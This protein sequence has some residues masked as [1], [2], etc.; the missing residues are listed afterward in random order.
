MH[1]ALRPNP[2]NGY[3]RDPGVLRRLERRFDDDHPW[4][5]GQLEAYARAP[6]TF[7]I[8]RVLWLKGVE[9]A[10]EETT[11]L[12]F[13]SVAH[14]ILERFYAEFMD[15]LPLSLTGSAEIRL[16]EISEEVC[17]ERVEKG[18]W[19]GVAA[20]WEQ[21]RQ[22]IVTGVRDYV[23]WELEYMAGQ[24][25][26]PVHTELRFGWDDERTFVEGED[27]WGRMSRVSLRGSIDRV[28]RVGVGSGVHH[29]LDYKSSWTPGAPSFDD[30]TSL[31][32]VLYARVMADRGYEMGS[33]RYRAIKKPGNP[34]NGGT[35]AFGS[36]RYERALSLALTIPARVRSGCFE[37]VASRK[38]NWKPWDPGL[39][40]RRNH[41]RL[42]EGHRFAD[43]GDRFGDHPRDYGEGAGG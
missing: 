21:T 5:A 23:A 29:V 25:E 1:P 20:L 6:F 9:E 28:D 10:E 17:A 22:G 7:L 11:P 34:Q 33:S 38:G 40:I 16:A 19:L 13:G 4:S 41:A 42:T 32:G 35:V 31:Q 8:E 3:L 37:A 43:F 2:W 36:E 18:E 15:R 26:R 27:V 24:G 12:V 39:A 30:A 14:E